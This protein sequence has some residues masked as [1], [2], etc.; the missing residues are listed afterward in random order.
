MG[1]SAQRVMPSDSCHIELVNLEEVSDETGRNQRAIDHTGPRIPMPNRPPATP[2][3]G[4][5]FGG[6]EGNDLP[7]EAPESLST[8]PRSEREEGCACALECETS[9]ENAFELSENE[10]RPRW[11]HADILW[12]CRHGNRKEE[13]VRL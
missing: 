13:C 8:Y 10:A 2:Q 7:D 5:D 1:G 11:T 4:P 9:K 12:R 6:D 3:E